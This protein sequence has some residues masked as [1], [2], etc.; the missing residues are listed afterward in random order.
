[1]TK[2]KILEAIKGTEFQGE[3]GTTIATAI[4]SLGDKEQVASGV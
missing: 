3:L 2:A 1:M 4:N